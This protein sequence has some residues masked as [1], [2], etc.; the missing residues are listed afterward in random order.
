ME[1]SDYKPQLIGTRRRAIFA[2]CFALYI[3]ATL[4]WELYRR[5]PPRNYFYPDDLGTAHW[6]VAGFNIF[7]LGILVLWLISLVSVC[8]H[9]RGAERVY[10][11]GWLVSILL[12]PVQSLVDRSTAMVLVWGKAFLWAAALFAAILIYRKLPPGVR[13]STSRAFDE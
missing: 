6:L 2:L 5:H 8:R 1:K 3:L 12:Y 11:A 10:L 7:L 13:T 4:T 9:C